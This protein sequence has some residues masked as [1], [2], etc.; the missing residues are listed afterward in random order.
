[1]NSKAKC[2]HPFG[3]PLDHLAEKSSRHNEKGM[4]IQGEFSP[5]RIW[6]GPVVCSRYKPY[7]RLS[8]YRNWQEKKKKAKG[9][10]PMDRVQL[11]TH[12]ISLMMYDLLQKHPDFNWA[13][14]KWKDIFFC[15]NLELRELG[16]EADHLCGETLCLEYR[17]LEWVTPQ[18]N[19][20]RMQERLKRLKKDPE[21]G[22][23]RSHMRGGITNYK[24]GQAELFVSSESPATPSVLSESDLPLFSGRYDVEE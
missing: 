18:Q 7:G 16:V 1:M 9:K 10:Y 24:R 22:R 20:E 5:C 12:R 13:E 4:I 8:L 3:G 19:E 15:Y 2:G 14:Q 17:H 21:F 11:R 23:M 6:T